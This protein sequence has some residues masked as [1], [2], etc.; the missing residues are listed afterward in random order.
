MAT[1][2]F[3]TSSATPDL[4]KAMQKKSSAG[5]MAFVPTSTSSCSEIHV[6]ADFAYDEA[7]QSLTATVPEVPRCRDRCDREPI[8]HI[9]RGQAGMV[10]GTF[11]RS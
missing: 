4:I 5:T 1:Y 3:D 6:P 11:K 2:I 10:V 8:L 7:L 9:L